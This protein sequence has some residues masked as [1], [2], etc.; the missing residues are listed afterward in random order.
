MGGLQWAFWG[1]APAGAPFVPAIAQANDLSVGNIIEAMAVIA[2]TLPSPV[3]V[4]AAAMLTMARSATPN[5]GDSVD[6]GKAAVTAFLQHGEIGIPSG[7]TTVT[8]FQALRD[9]SVEKTNTQGRVNLYLQFATGTLRELMGAWML[10]SKILCTATIQGLRYLGLHPG[11]LVEGGA[12]RGGAGFADFRPQLRR[13]VAGQLGEFTALSASIC[14]AARR[15][16]GLEFPVQMEAALQFH[17]SEVVRPQLQAMEYGAVPYMTEPEFSRLQGPHPRELPAIVKTA[18]SEPGFDCTPEKADEMAVAAILGHGAGNISF[19]A[20]FKSEWQDGSLSLQNPSGLGP[21][22]GLLIASPTG[23]ALFAGLDNSLTV[24]RLEVRRGSSTNSGDRVGAAVQAELP[25]YEHFARLS[26][27][28]LHPVDNRRACRKKY[29]S[30]NV[31][32]FPAYELLYSLRLNDAAARKVLSTRTTANK[33]VYYDEIES[34]VAVNALPYIDPDEVLPRLLVNVFGDYG[35]GSHYTEPIGFGSVGFRK[36][37]RVLS[38][39]RSMGPQ[40]LNMGL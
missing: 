24:Q 20:N 6:R 1:A 16:F 37:E 27:L 14:R 7:S 30:G 2:R 38:R 25:K 9:L 12:W 5:Y 19:S 35:L 23:G 33:L 32:M 26:N 11:V 22:V 8:T 31:Q 21:G 3:A 29:V 39:V 40:S 4:D 28:R 15:C 13:A 10:W 18:S 36:C 17:G 34:E